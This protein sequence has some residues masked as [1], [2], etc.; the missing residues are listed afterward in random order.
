MQQKNFHLTI[1]NGFMFCKIMTTHPQL[2][3][4]LLEMIL[5]VPIR[6]IRF[7]ESQKTIDLTADSKSVWLDVYVDD[8]NGTVY[9]SEMQTSSNV[10]LP[11]RSR[12][13]QGMI[14]LNLLEKGVDYRY[15]PKS[16]VIFIC[17]FDPFGK[18]LISLVCQN[19]QKGR[20]VS[21]IADFLGAEE[22]LITQI[23][24]IASVQ[25]PEYNVEDIYQKLRTCKL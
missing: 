23:Y 12:Y 20:T 1:A 2:C 22:S 25:M 15:L 19:M 11:K 21:D 17:T 18:E 7:S 16:F 5:N 13:Y 9:D 4:H 6:E 3:K 10:N 24:N 8:E 14:D